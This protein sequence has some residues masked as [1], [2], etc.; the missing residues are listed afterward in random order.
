MILQD[1]NLED[2]NTNLETQPSFGSTTA[3]VRPA[4]TYQIEPAA[5]TN[6]NESSYGSNIVEPNIVN[7][8]PN[9]QVA[10]VFP[11]VVSAND[12]IQQPTVSDIKNNSIKTEVSTNQ[13]S[14]SNGGKTYVSGGTTPNASIVI[15]KPKTNYLLYGVV[16]LLGILIINRLFFY[17]K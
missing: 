7:L 2:Q 16:G 8:V 5:E 17:K 13:N 15:K 9:A 12:L 1:S 6:Y 4:L 14:A 3:N 10:P 11:Q